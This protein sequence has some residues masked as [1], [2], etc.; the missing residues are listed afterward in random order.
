LKRK[1]TSRPSIKKSKQNN[2]KKLKKLKKKKKKKK[3]VSLPQKHTP[4]PKQKGQS[5]PF[6]SLV[7]SFIKK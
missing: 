4:G 2:N 3:K 5:S 1:P 7:Q 6:N